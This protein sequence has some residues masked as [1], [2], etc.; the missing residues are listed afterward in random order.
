MDLPS[1]FPAVWCDFNACGWSGQ[2]DDDC[3]YVL[4]KKRLEELKATAGMRVFLYDDDI[5]DG[6]PGV[7]GID[8]ELIEDR[9]SLIARPLEETFYSGLRFW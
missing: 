3:Y 2:S 8:A 7:V 6:R 9:G 4:D 1:K 5:I